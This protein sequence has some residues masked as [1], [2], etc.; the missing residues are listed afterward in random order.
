[1]N[2]KHYVSGERNHYFFGKLMTVRDFEHEQ[3]YHNH[4]RRLGNRMLH[5]AGIVSGLGVFLVD[6][7]SI[8]LERGMAIDYLGREIVVAESGIR[9]LRTI[10]GF[11][12]CQ[13][14]KQVYLCIEYAEELK[15]TTF[16]VS[17]TAA[18][19]DVGQEFNRIAEGYR[20]F[21]THKA[22]NQQ[23]QLDLCHLHTS[24]L[25]LIETENLRIVAEIPRDVNP[26]QSLDIAL[27]ITKTQC[28]APVQYDLSLYGTLFRT[29]ENQ[30]SLY[31]H[32]EETDVDEYHQ[33]T[34]TYTLLCDASYDG[35][36]SLS[37]KLTCG[38]SE[39]EET[40]S[41]QVTSQR[42]RDVVIERYYAQHFDDILAVQAE[43]CL[44]LAQIHLISNEVSYFIERLTQ[45]PFRQFLLNS[46]LL[47]TLEAMPQH[48]QGTVLPEASTTPSLDLTCI[49]EQKEEESLPT[50]AMHTGVQRISLGFSPKAG[51]SF[52]S[53]DIIHGFG[54][55]NVAVVLAVEN[56]SNILTGEDPVILFG[57]GDIFEANTLPDS[58][59]R[60]RLGAMVYP[61]K[62]LLKIGVKLLS[63]TNL[64]AIDV[65]WWA[66]LVDETEAGTEAYHDNIR[67]LITP[68]TAQVAPLEQVRFQASIEGLLNQEVNW[69]VESNSGGTIDSNGLYTAPSK[70]GVYAIIAQS[71][72]YE[73]K[74]EVA[75]VIV[76]R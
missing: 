47:Q 25:P 62:G 30:E 73:Q 35:M 39:V 52:L 60:V 53:A 42:I 24:T 23:E 26:G 48:C 21:L 32:F 71:V 44:Y 63:S 59:P 15:E 7:Q 43:H 16:A 3:R 56:Q 10:D 17:K 66:Y 67:V 14:Q 18:T 9:P 5:G 28:P 76:M 49:D 13:G 74:K 1:M 29:S 40:V 27:H 8:S 64:T 54:N 34:E 11:A 57:D 65:R 58:M 61:S 37:L 75:Y 68:D 22:P 36:A 38:E 31:S 55:A 2:Q 72:K 19:N 33:F 12:E 46:Q 70:E 69:S 20:L 4:K 41:V 45:F 50:V 6:N 51:K